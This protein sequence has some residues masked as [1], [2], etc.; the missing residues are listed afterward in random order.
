[1]RPQLLGITDSL[2]HNLLV[3]KVVEPIRDKEF[4]M[5]KQGGFSRWCQRYNT[6]LHHASCP[7]EHLKL[8]SYWTYYW[9][10]SFLNGLSYRINY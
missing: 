5:W 10:Y 8:I 9:I 4:L 2:S 1:M 7:C 3:L 6:A